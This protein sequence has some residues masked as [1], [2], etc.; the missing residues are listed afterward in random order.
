MMNMTARDEINSGVNAKEDP[1][2]Q[3]EKGGQ[4]E[5]GNEKNIFHVHLNTA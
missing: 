1:A 3:K 5:T 4:S 2:D